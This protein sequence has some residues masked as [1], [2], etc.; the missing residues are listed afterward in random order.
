MTDF[1]AMV[2]EGTRKL[3][4]A[5]SLQVVLGCGLVLEDRLCASPQGSNSVLCEGYT[6]HRGC[7]DLENEHQLERHLVRYRQGSLAETQRE[8]LLYLSGSTDKSRVYGLGMANAC[9]C[10]PNNMAFWA[11]PS[12]LRH[13]KHTT[14][15]C[16]HNFVV[17][18]WF[19][20]TVKSMLRLQ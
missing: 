13:L 12:V 9:F 3:W 11:P 2:F 16:D 18:V 20:A 5:V 4:G 1:C 6:I 19:R 14:E 8:P 7:L 15:L 17:T 10:T